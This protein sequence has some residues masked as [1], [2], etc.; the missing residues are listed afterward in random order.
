MAVES[1]VQRA[2]TETLRFFTAHARAPHYTELAR[3]LGLSPEGGRRLMRQ[4][5]D[6]ADREGAAACWM[7]A[8]TDY[9]EGWA[10]FSNLPTHHRLKIDGREGWYGQ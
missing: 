9:V 1:E 10:P 3:I 7:A 5:A 2:F 4:A 8:D 6:V